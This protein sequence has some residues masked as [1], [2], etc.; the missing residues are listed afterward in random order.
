MFLTEGSGGTCG[1]TESINETSH[2]VSNRNFSLGG[3]KSLHHK[4]FF[5]VNFETVM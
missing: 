3:R 1:T 4:F 2:R 5:A